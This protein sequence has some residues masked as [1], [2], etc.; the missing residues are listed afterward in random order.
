MQL[1]CTM[2]R[3]LR[4]TLLVT[5]ILCAVHICFMDNSWTTRKSSEWKKLILTHHW[6]VTVCKMAGKQCQEPPNY[7]TLHGLWTDKSQSCNN[8]WPFDCSEIQDILTDMNKWWPDVLHPN[9]SQLWK[10]E[11]QKHGTCAASLPCLDTQH[12]YFSK[13]LELYT[14]MDLTS[15]LEKFG[16]K[17]AQTYKASDI[18]NAMVKTYGVVPRIQCLPPQQG[19]D[20]QILGQIEV[21]FTKSFDLENCTGH[22]EDELTVPEQTN[23]GASSDELHVCDKTLNIYYPPVQ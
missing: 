14:H 12:K 20:N 3:P 5:S 11:W 18:E 1:F 15:V 2:E 22:S 19:E 10:H 7:W 6:P 21:C 4:N 23:W 9:H 13:G 16:I 17:P 8:S